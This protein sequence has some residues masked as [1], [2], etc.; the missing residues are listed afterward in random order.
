MELP[1][2]P[3]PPRPRDDESPG[4]AR[5]PQDHLPETMP[6]DS[7]QS[8]FGVDAPPRSSAT[9]PPSSLRGGNTE[10]GSMTRENG[11]GPTIKEWKTNGSREGSAPAW[12]RNPA[13]A[14]HLRRVEESSRT[15][16]PRA[17]GEASRHRDGDGKSPSNS[18][19]CASGAVVGSAPTTSDRSTR[20]G[21]QGPAEHRPS[22]PQP[23]HQPPFSAPHHSS[24]P[25]RPATQPAAACEERRET[26]MPPGAGPVPRRC[27]AAAR[28]RPD[29]LPGRTGSG[30]G[31]APAAVG[32]AGPALRHL[33][34]APPR[35]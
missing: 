9:S 31:A 22:S 25:I 15:K 10:P 1:S 11:E 7:L 28:R 6:A 23:S 30:R 33:P 14:S 18:A 8:I 19:A 17:S 2:G 16:E 20:D 26:T 24:P 27:S 4:S 34:H 13:P 32:A 3:T 29:P 35:L 12:T 21:R 5:P